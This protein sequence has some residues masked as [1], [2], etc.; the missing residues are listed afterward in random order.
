MKEWAK[1]SSLEQELRSG[2]D[3]IELWGW[4]EIWGACGTWGLIQYLSYNLSKLFL[5]KRKNLICKL[6]MNLGILEPVPLPQPWLP[7]CGRRA[8]TCL[9]HFVSSGA[10]LLLAPPSHLLDSWE[11]A[12][13][14]IVSCCS[15]LT[16]PHSIWN[17]VSLLICCR[18]PLVQPSYPHC[19]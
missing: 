3:H 6:E 15:I 10:P 17:N 19:E 16:S 11:C 2:S 13:F 7:L 12:A 1:P 4:A 14:H 18:R 8:Q 5:L 9:E